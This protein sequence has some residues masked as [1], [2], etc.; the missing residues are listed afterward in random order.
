MYSFTGHFAKMENLTVNLQ[1]VYGSYYKKWK[2]YRNFCKR[3]TGQILKSGNPTVIPCDYNEE[4][5]GYFTEN[6]NLA[7]SGAKN[8]G[9][10]RKN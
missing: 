5:T 4:F 3:F 6:G 1:V 10:F 7:V 2:S 9:S 8:Y